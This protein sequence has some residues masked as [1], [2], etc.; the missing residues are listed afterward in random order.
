MK[1]NGVTYQQTVSITEMIH[2]VYFNEKKCC[3][4]VQIFW[5]VMPCRWIIFLDV[6]KKRDAFL[7]VVQEAKQQTVTSRKNLVFNNT[8]ASVSN[9]GRRCSIG[10]HNPY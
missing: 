3:Y 1:L 5:G 7:Y 8:S 10:V 2:S 6:S 9:L 4:K